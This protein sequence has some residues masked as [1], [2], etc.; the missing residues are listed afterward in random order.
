MKR[1]AFAML[2][3]LALTA[4]T[5]DSYDKGES[6][7][8]TMQADFVEAHTNSDLQV[9][10]V[11]TDDDE[12]LVM[13]KPFAQDWIKKG[14]SIYRSVLYYKKNEKTVEPVSIAPISVA[15]ISNADSLAKRKATVKTDPLTIESL[16]VS[17]NKRYLNASIHLKSGSTDNKDAMHKLG[18]VGDSVR[19]NRDK[20]RTL[21]VRMHHDQG[22]MP[23]YYSVHTYFSVAL[24][25][26]KVDSIELRVNT[27]SGWI[28]KHISLK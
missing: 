7:Y 17:K 21:C 16:W 25:S 10:Y 6:D 5:N 19:T 28:T 14:D 11:M 1:L 18:L 20:T 26:I 4:C 22:G 8:S 9:D 12:R 15:T 27:Y 23:E 3:L 24:D 2:S 13:D